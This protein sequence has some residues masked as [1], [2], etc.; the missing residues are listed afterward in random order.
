MGEIALVYM[1]A[2]ISSRFLG[3]IKQFAVVGSKGET[4]IEYSLKQALKAGFSKI[5]FIVGN[6]TEKLFKEKF[7]NRYQ[8]IPVYYAYQ[9]YDENL[10]ERPWGSTD[11]LCSI[12]SMIDCPFVVCNGDDLYGEN[13]FKIL[14]E[15]LKKNNNC[16]AIGFKLKD[17]L[18]EQGKTNRGIFQTDKNGFVTE[19][20]EIIG[21]EKSDLGKIFSENSLCSMN[22]FAFQQEML[23][24][25]SV[26]LEQFK[27]KHKEDRRIE[28]LLPEDI[29]TLIRQKKISMNLYSTPDEWIGITNPEDEEIVRRKL[30]EL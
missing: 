27:E 17:V 4:L 7:G 30:A 18:P 19:I 16:A 14:A 8:G 13:S 15:H 22:I 6:K 9:F 2:G 23:N 24:D 5:I 1:V 26:I 21:I 28:A 12:K 3:K 20:K 25:L 11:A 29:S 10:R